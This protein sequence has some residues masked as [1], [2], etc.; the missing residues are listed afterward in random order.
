MFF[1]ILLPVLL[2]IGFVDYSRAGFEGMND[3]ASLKI[4]NRVNCGDGINCSRGK[5]GIFNIVN[6]SG[7]SEVTVATATTITPEQ[8]GSTFINGGAIQIELPEASSVIGCKLTFAVG[9]ASNFD[10][11]P[12]D[13]DQ[14]LIETD[15]AGDSIRSS[16]LGNTIVI[17]AISASEWA[18]IGTVGTWADN[19]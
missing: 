18:P 17:Q 13:G 16:T 6:T 3:G 10:I 14:I 1:K 8:C 4:F 7:I 2:M 11:N 19:D 5:N 15:A 12:D 9:N